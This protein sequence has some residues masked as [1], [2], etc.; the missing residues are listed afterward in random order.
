MEG[1]HR[2]FLTSGR[3]R[4]CAQTRCLTRI[5]KN[6]AN[7]PP[8]NTDADVDESVVVIRGL[9]HDALEQV[10]EMVREM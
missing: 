2:R 7:A 3:D 9:A 8:N 10:T 4:T 1:L 5:G 6:P